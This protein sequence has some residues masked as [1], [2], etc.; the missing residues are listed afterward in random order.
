MELIA[1]L[2]EVLKYKHPLTKEKRTFKQRIVRNLI[3]RAATCGD[4]FDANGKLIKEG[5][6]DLQAI[7]A[8]FDRLEGS[9]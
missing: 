7:L 4:E 9:T 3:R 5:D 8:I 1:Q 2:D 6:G